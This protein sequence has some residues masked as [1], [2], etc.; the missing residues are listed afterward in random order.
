VKN[1]I[2][3][4]KALLDWAA[5]NGIQWDGWDDAYGDAFG[6]RLAFLLSDPDE[7]PDQKKWETAGV[8]GHAVA[9]LLGVNLR[10]ALH[11]HLIRLNSLPL[12][13]WNS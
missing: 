9:Q 7:E 10:Q 3:A 6:S 4:N 12:L 13:P 2:K 5:N 1:G 11:E 8:L